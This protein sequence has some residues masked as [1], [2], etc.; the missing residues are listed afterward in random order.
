[1]KST[2]S[3]DAFTKVGNAIR[4]IDTWYAEEVAFPIAAEPYGAVT[5]LGT[6]FRQPK[7]KKNDFYT[8]FDNWL[9]KGEVPPVEQQHY[10]MSV[11]IRGGVFGA[12][13]KE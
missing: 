8:L 1:M 10:V 11:L 12:S 9:L 2:K 6:A 4:T 7:T 3:G 13:G 5:T